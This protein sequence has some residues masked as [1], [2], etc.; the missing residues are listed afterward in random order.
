MRLL[1]VQKCLKLTELLFL[2]HTCGA[3]SE[4]QSNISSM[5]R[6]LSGIS[7]TAG[8]ICSWS[9]HCIII[10]DNLP[11]ARSIQYDVKTKLIDI[12]QST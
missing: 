6:P 7:G 4:L 9:E 1:S 2:F 8:I 11:C 5:G 3:Y 12:I 10:P